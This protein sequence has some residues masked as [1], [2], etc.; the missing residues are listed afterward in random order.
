MYRYFDDAELLA[1]CQKLIDCARIP[2]DLVYIPVENTRR[3]HYKTPGYKRLRTALIAVVLLLSISIGVAAFTGNI[4]YIPGVGTFF[5]DKNKITHS[6]E[7]AV[8]LEKDGYTHK[9]LSGYLEGGRISLKLFYYSAYLDVTPEQQYNIDI[10][11]SVFDSPVD[12]NVYY[13]GK[14]CGG[15]SKT[16]GTSINVS[17][18]FPS[19]GKDKEITVSLYSGDDYYIGDITLLPIERF[20]EANCEIPV[21]VVHDMPVMADVDRRNDQMAVYISVLLPDDA[22]R[23][24][25]DNRENGFKENDIYITDSEGNIFRCTSYNSHE[26]GP[27]MYSFYHIFYFNIPKDKTDLKIVIPSISYYSKQGVSK[28]ITVN[29][30]WEINLN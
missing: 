9:I 15:Y 24:F 26:Y 10:I 17:F 23:G 2:D 12:Y 14:K 18:D 30:P 7:G 3:V 22:K 21:T 8:T 25:V 5:Q 11:N 19:V 16:Y 13:N 27:V 29:G 28:L 20:Y 6:I 1:R 4:V